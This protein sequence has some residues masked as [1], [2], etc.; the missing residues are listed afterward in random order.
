MGK[1]VVRT[2]F[3]GVIR[4]H[5][6]GIKPLVIVLAACNHVLNGA[7]LSQIAEYCTLWWTEDWLPRVARE[8]WKSNSEF[9]YAG[10]GQ[11]AEWI[12]RYRMEGI[13]DHTWIPVPVSMPRPGKPYCYADEDYIAP[14]CGNS[15]KQKYGPSP[16]IQYHIYG[17][18][19]GYLDKP[20]TYFMN[21]DGSLSCSIWVEPTLH[22]QIW[23]GQ[24]ETEAKIYLLEQPSWR[25]IFGSGFLTVG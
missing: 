24:A 23:P 11:P 13:A 22:I 18:K 1:P 17:D 3:T 20:G 8:S 9:G 4:I 14:F 5:I 19:M 15:W 10:P 16:A 6:C 7:E 21:E 25:D 2:S 12:K